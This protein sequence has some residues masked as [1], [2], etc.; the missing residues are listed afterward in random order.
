[1]NII[2]QEWKSYQKSLLCW[3]IGILI[4]L[5][6]SFYKV[7]GLASTVQMDTFMKTMPTVIQLL[8]GSMSD[9]NSGIDGYRMIHLYI[10]IVLALHAVILGAGIFAKEERDKT[11]EFLYVKGVKRSHIL[12]LKIIASLLVLV[13]LNGICF[14]GVYG[15]S[16]FMDMPL[17][18]HELLPYIGVVFLTQ[19]FF[20]SLALLLS[21][22]RWSGK[23]A[24]SIGCAI[25]FLMFFIDIYVKLGG[26]AEFMDS[27][28]IFRYTDVF[29]IQNESLLP[30]IVIIL[31]SLIALWLSQRLHRQ[32]D[33]L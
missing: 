31:C 3:S 2:R 17:V 11:A 26:K 27:F 24:G 20:F 5:F 1:M 18:F 21:L 6:T 22:L 28:S 25:V 19:L 13:S 10:V 15:S 8:F 4:L 32:H 23:H 16:I 9:I 33:F 29:Y 12:H 30:F 7:Q 14:L